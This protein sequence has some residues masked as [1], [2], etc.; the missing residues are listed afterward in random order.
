MEE[1]I[2]DIRSNEGISRRPEW[3]LRNKPKTDEALDLV[4]S[5]VD[6]FY[7]L[8]PPSSN[9]PAAELVYDPTLL[10]EHVYQIKTVA[11]IEGTDPLAAG[12]SSLKIATIQLKSRSGPFKR[13]PAQKKI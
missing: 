8:L 13:Y 2:R 1:Q 11:N 6:D 10:T 9:D 7:R 12:M 5:L 3:A 4:N